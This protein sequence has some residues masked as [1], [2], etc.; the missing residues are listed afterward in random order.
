[1]PIQT[2]GLG[3]LARLAAIVT[4]TPTALI[5]LLDD[6]RE[7]HQARLVWPTDELPRERSLLA[8][9]LR[10]ENTWVSEDLHTDARTERHPYR[11]EDPDARF[12]AVAPVRLDDMIVGGLCVRDTTARGLSVAE[13]SVLEAIALEVTQYLA[14]ADVV[15]RDFLNALLDTLPDS[16]YFKNRRS[17]FLR[18]S[19]SLATTF[20]LSDP[21]DAVGKT[22]LDFFG[23]AHAHA[24][25]ED[26]RRIVET[27][28]PVVGKLE[29]EGLLLGQERWVSTTKVPLRN[30]WGAIIG[31]L[32][33]SRDV[34][35]L[36][37]YEDELAVARDA[38]L[39]SARVKSE[40]LANMSHEIRTP[41][42]AV[43]GM[44]GLL[45]DTELDSE[46]RDFAT[47]IRTSADLLLGVI[48]D[49]LDISKM[50]AGRMQIETIDFDF[51]QIVEEAAELLADRAQSK[52]IELV[53]W[54][55]EDVPRWLRGDPG[56]IRQV[57]VNLIG[58]AVKFTEEG[59]VLVRVSAEESAPGGRTLR[60]EVQDT[61]IGVPAEARDKLFAA[62]T[63]A[64]GSM[65]RR[66]G[67]T[68]L[69]LAICRSLVQLMG[70]DIGFVGRSTGGTTFWFTLPLVPAASPVASAPRDLVSLEGARVLIVDDNATNREILRHQTAAW[71]MRHDSAISGPDAIARLRQAHAGGDPYALVILD[72]QMPDMDGM[73]VARAIK[74]DRALRGTRLVVLTS[75][76]HHASDAELRAA[77]I[78]AY[79]TKPVKQSRLF[80]SLVIAMSD[81]D[82][83]AQRRR[84]VAPASAVQENYR[85]VRV[86]LAED[87]AVNQ[88][89]ALRQL[90]K[91][92][93]EADAVGDGQEVLQSIVRTPYDVIL[94]DCQMPNLDG[95]ETTRRIRQD[96]ARTPSRRRVHI[97]ALT[98]HAMPGDREA[99]LAAGM[100]DYVSKP[101]R[102]D[103]LGQALSRARPRTAASQ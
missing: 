60:V 61:G 26:E 44:S 97:I 91:L 14:P 42:N 76:A 82:A 69:G 33:L 31:T 3:N 59:E 75:L 58:N 81:G 46:Q 5:T 66:Y 89:V 39:E 68:G 13:Q 79:L 53:T 45:L 23:A 54:M 7:I 2:P 102:L 6:T 71:R 101:M 20:G 32:G 27:G 70:G 11:L 52:G 47:T 16:V 55:P 15:S 64:D 95:Y 74:S 17:Q 94:M 34:T 73:A 49:V 87:N 63:Q 99:C 19:R 48:N 25:R 37:Q 78:A 51:T 24:A 9:A 36:K 30:Q 85:G 100:D 96:E 22:D 43:V 40:F 98:A 12:F 77:G 80:D 65:T 4:R 21:A 50:D 8:M 93:I 62:F 18:I 88:K 103:E 35:L 57:L 41:L 56:R 10:S 83:P 38:A 86:L 29:R 84:S 1:M 28:E 90:Q 92:G 67:G 72:M